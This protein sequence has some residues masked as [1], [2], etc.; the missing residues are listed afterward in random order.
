MRSLTRYAY[1]RVVLRRTITA[2]EVVEIIVG[3]EHEP[4]SLS[5]EEYVAVR[6]ILEERLTEMF[7]WR[8]N[9]DDLAEAVE[10]AILFHFPGRSYFLEI[11]RGALDEWVQVYEMNGLHTRR[12][13]G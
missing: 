6:A 1:V 12:S 8:A 3:V 10:S 7:V 11:G 5:S 4:A 2:G 13:R 9:D